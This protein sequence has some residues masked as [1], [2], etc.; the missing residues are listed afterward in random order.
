LRSSVCE[1]FFATL[2]EHYDAMKKDSRPM[3][4][5]ALKVAR[6]LGYV[7]AGLSALL[8]ILVVGALVVL[9]FKDFNHYKPLIAEEAR[10]AT[11]REL[12]ISGDVRLH[13]SFAPG[14]VV[15]GVT[16]SNAAWG[17]R[18]DMVSVTRLKAQ[19]VLTSLIFGVV[20][21]ARIELAGADILLETDSQGRANFDFEPPAGVAEEPKQPEAAG[22]G[23]EVIPMVNEAVI[24]ESR[25]TH[26][27]GVTGA[28]YSTV[29]DTLILSSD[30]PD[31][32]INL[33]YAGSYNDAPIRANATLGTVAGL[34]EPAT[35]WPVDLAIEAG[36][37][38]VTVKGTIAEPLTGSGVDL[39]LTVR[40]DE[41]GDLSEL[42]GTDV[43]KLGAYSLSARVTGDT[44]TVI[45]FAG[46][47]AQ[48]GDSNLS[49]EVSVK[50]TG[51][52][53][54][55]EADLESEEIDLAALGAGV[56][57]T[58]QDA[59]TELSL[60]DGKLEIESFNAKLA[61]A[62]VALKGT[63]AEPLAGGGLDLAASLKGDQTGDLS[64]IVGAKVPAL[65][66]FSVSARVTGDVASKIR[67]AGLKA[68]I[69]ASTLTGEATVTPGGE[70]PAIDAKLAS[71]QID[72]A[73]L[74]AG[75]DAK[76]QNTAADLSL[77]DPRSR[78]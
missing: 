77:K 25:L 52:Q 28:S 19:V 62:A 46:L 8:I 38:A 50:L 65:G 71:R 53:A 17:S 48:L 2:I 43:L 76:L 74:G 35:P 70:R 12:A 45:E 42:A 44:A 4:R 55:I 18:P 60:K 78:A 10:K 41:L 32:P 54:A 22:T 58:L 67:L 68:R 1:R 14:I 13:I 51:E 37:G 72:L 40:G 57:A 16:L 3:G 9:E 7:L 75:V 73:A 27:N 11:G 66:A 63:V 33:V 59:I 69:G 56:S 64:E 29:V 26:I 49:G 6:I 23:I 15:E 61:G 24:R 34:L 30:G 20:E 21:F 47:K 5:R 36:G 39:A 31:D